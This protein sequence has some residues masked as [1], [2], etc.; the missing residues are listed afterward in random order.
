MVGEQELALVAYTGPGD[1]AVQRESSGVAWR[2]IWS[3]WPA[4]KATIHVVRVPYRTY[5]LSSVGASTAREGAVSKCKRTPLEMVSPVRD[6]FPRKWLTVADLL[7]GTCEAR[8]GCVELLVDQDAER[9]DVR[10][11]ILP[12]SS[13]E[14]RRRRP[15]RTRRGTAGADTDGDGSFE[16]AEDTRERCSS[17]PMRRNVPNALVVKFVVRCGELGIAWSCKSLKG[18]APEVGLNLQPSGWQKRPRRSTKCD[19]GR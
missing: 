13:M 17:D 19:E 12:F 5:R 2:M 18:L 7:A 9:V 1:C 16:A 11:R 8:S 14:A 3:S 4:P 10:S 6:F 15:S